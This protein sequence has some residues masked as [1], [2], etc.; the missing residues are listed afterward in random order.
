M[1]RDLI[2]N[3]RRG[4]K[5]IDIAKAKGMDTSEWESRLQRLLA[6]A[7]LEPGRGEGF[8]PWAL[9]EWRR[10]SIPPWRQILVKS[11]ADGDWRR[12]EY[13]R[14]MLWEVLL[15]PDYDEGQTC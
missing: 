1:S 2:E 4:R 9:W 7:S 11:I 15:D 13:S 3:I 14:W 10:V 8:E 6:Q 12:E 5:A